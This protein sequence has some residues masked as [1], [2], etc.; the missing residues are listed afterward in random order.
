[1]FRE[2]YGISHGTKEMFSSSLAMNDE[3]CM[4]QQA[5]PHEATISHFFLG[6]YSGQL[7]LIVTQQSCYH[8]LWLVLMVI[9]EIC[10]HSLAL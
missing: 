10:T 3:Q 1:M 7:T 5:K 9:A 6:W 4:Q 8:R 2:I